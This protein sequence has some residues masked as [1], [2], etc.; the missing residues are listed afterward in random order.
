MVQ[1]HVVDIEIFSWAVIV[2]SLEFILSL[3]NS[4][5]RSFC[6]SGISS[7]VFSIV[8]IEVYIPWV[9]SF[10]ILSYFIL[11]SFHS[12]IV[13]FLNTLVF[14]CSFTFS[15]VFFHSYIRSLFHPLVYDINLLY[16]NS[17]THFNGFISQDVDEL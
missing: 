10:N 16:L 14:F 11:L 9:Y 15:F 1:N 7:F 4:F 5:I 13:S 12:F 2:I 8:W 6:Q 3:L 17:I